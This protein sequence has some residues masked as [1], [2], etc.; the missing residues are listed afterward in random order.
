MQKTLIVLVA[1]VGF[2]SASSIFRTPIT[3][4]R[5]STN[6]SINMTVNNGLYR[7]HVN[8]VWKS[9]KETDKNYLV[10]LYSSQF[11]LPPADGVAACLNF[12]GNYD[13]GSYPNSCTP[14]SNPLPAPLPVAISSPYFEGTGTPVTTQIWVDYN[15][16]ILS[17]A[18]GAPAPAVTAFT[19]DNNGGKVG[20]EQF[21]GANGIVGLGIDGAAKNNFVNG[22]KNFWV[23]IGNNT[24]NIKFQS[25]ASTPDFYQKIWSARTDSNWGINVANGVKIGDYSN[26]AASRLIFDFNFKTNGFPKAIYDNIIIELN[27]IKGVKCPTDSNSDPK[28]T[29]TVKQADWKNLTLNIAADNQVSLNVFDLIQNSNSLEEKWT[30]FTLNIRA[31]SKDLTS[32][33]HVTAATDAANTI[34]L[35]AN[36]MRRYIYIF[37]IA[38]QSVTVY[39]SSFGDAIIKGLA[40]FLK[41]IIIAIVGSIIICCLCVCFCCGGTA[42]IVAKLGKKDK[43]DNYYQS[44]QTDPFV[45]RK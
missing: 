24:A 40:A 36:T 31:L 29:G 15:S 9:D 45:A 23:S 39:Y 30:D 7:A 35:G 14:L 33:N 20:E 41:W 11:L 32:I 4:L 12:A 13:C 3:E 18:V 43:Q 21:A 1:L 17:N 8:Y 28:C 10:A 22:T 27:K 2:L 42:W 38:D 25:N 34:I 37:S 26:P 6:S 44:S 16:W 19:C 5:A